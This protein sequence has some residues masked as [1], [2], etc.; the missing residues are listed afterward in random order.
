[1]RPETL[2]EQKKSQLQRTQSKLTDLRESR[3]KKKQKQ[4]GSA[5]NEVKCIFTV[6]D[7]K[8]LEIEKESS[9]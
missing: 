7:V 3:K 6:L 4:T 5:K 1:M 2:I 8:F 9:P